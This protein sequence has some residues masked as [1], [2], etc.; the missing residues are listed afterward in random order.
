MKSN[1][2]PFLFSFPKFD[3]SGLKLSFFNSTNIRFPVLKI[4]KIE[5][6]I[7]IIQ[8]GMGVGIS[9]S[10]LASAVAEEGGIGVIAANAIGMIDPNYYKDGKGANIRTLRQEIRKAREKGTG[11]LGVN[12]MVAVNDFYDLLQVS[13]EEKVDIIFLG[14]GLPL[15]NIPLDSIRKQKISIVPIVSSARAAKLIFSYWKKNYND[16]PDAVVVEGPKAGGHLGFSREEIDNPDFALEKIIP[17]VIE[18]VS[19]FEKESGKSIPV[20]A[21]GG[22]FTGEDIFKF[23]ELGASGVQMASRFVATH[24]CDA[25]QRFKEVYVNSKPEDIVIIS[26][27]VGLPGRA[28]KNNFIEEMKSDNPR[29][30]R[31]AWRCLAHCKAHDARYCISE[32]LNNARQGKLDDGYA[33]AGANVA[34]I[35]K[36]V[37][38]K[39]L[40]SELRQEYITV[41]ENSTISLRNEFEKGINK[42]SILVDE[43]KKEMDFRIR[44]FR[45]ELETMIEKGA[46]A[47]REEYHVATSKI[48]RIKEEYSSHLERIDEIKNQLSRFFD[49]PDIVL[50][51]VLA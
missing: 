6:R 46:A 42:L 30:V 36:I 25:D 1:Q 38:V 27:P 12:I 31:C 5:S 2:T 16:I 47:I 51:K 32:A 22:I 49:T 17:T 9:L 29:R 43:Y 34:R 8:G 7:P 33:F 10:G 26:S 11:I 24:E 18:A 37:H 50:P 4:G 44:S 45:D 13:I 48:E 19:P 40:F 35:D 23:L 41:V 14:A 39:E 3:F 15:K 21:A 20:I 28:I